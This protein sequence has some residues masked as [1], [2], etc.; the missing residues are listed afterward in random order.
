MNPTAVL[1]DFA[2]ALAPGERVLLTERRRLGWR[3][4][5]A[6]GARLAPAM[7]LAAG[8][9][10]FAATY[11]SGGAP[12]SPW[13]LPLLVLGVPL[14]G[15]L[16]VALALRRHRPS[17]YEI[18][19]ACDQKP[20]HHDRLS[21]AVEFAAADH[22]PG[23][24]ATAAIEDARTRLD[25]LSRDLPALRPARVPQAR[26]ALALALLIACLP[27]LLP[28]SGGS[29]AAARPGVA[30]GETV[31]TTSRQ[32]SPAAALPV[33][34][35]EPPALAPTPQAR[36]SARKPARDPAPDPNAAPPLAL[37]D[38]AAAANPASE[39][40]SEGAA[41]GAGKAP[42]KQTPPPTSAGAPGGAGQSAGAAASPDT[43]A[44]EPKPVAKKRRTPRQPS[45]SKP[46][47]EA[48]SSGTPSGVSQGAGKMANVDSK[49][50]NRAQHSANQDE[51][52]APDED[53][54]DEKDES[55][56]RGGVAPLTRDRQQP[57]SREL[58][59]SGDG[60]PDDGRG[61]PTPPKK[62]R[63]TAA[64]IL[65][66][67]LADH[68]QGQPNPGTS[69]QDLSAA[70]PRKEAGQPAVQTASPGGAAPTH[71]SPHAGRFAWQTALVRY[72]ELLRRGSGAPTTD[73]N[74]ERNR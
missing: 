52:A 36:E 43:K 68:V 18:A 45:P 12:F 21:A 30:A 44:P 15:A 69:K 2:A 23:P 38:A 72:S 54:E 59:I 65:G 62:S 4:G 1:A 42:S 17:L 71:Q 27:A 40:G 8:L 51:Q 29:P 19:L 34:P 73:P 31:A 22:P 32:E 67:R 60:P 5:F 64:L 24:F 74:H 10:F 56:Q 66:V 50:D 70:P 46:N 57:P 9:G 55:E 28:T 37:Q 49:R 25:A 35:S 47:Q 14:A 39:T 6:V 13:L 7:A 48:D 53:V 63:G 33:P 61:G 58:S 16:A 3:S 20:D 26:G 11:L 41:A